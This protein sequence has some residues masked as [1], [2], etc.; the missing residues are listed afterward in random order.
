MSIAEILELRKAANARPAGTAVAVIGSGGKTT[1]VW[2]LASTFRHER[3]LVTT[4]VKMWLP[5][6]DQ[7]DAFPDPAVFTAAGPAAQAAPPGITFAGVR[8][9][10]EGKIGALPPEALA[11]RR[12]HFD[13]L[14]IEADGSR[15]RPYKGWADHEPVVPEWTDL[16]IAVLP[17]PQ[18][19]RIVSEACV[20]RLPEFLAISGA[21]PGEPLRPAHLAAA[22]A[23]PNGLLARARGR[24]VLFFSQ[25]ETGEA[26][27]AAEETAALLPPACRER[28]WKIVA[29]SACD[30]TA[31][32]I[33]ICRS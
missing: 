3:V 10:A 11:S 1:L 27:K 31:E 18:S 26:R 23:H 17:P 19:G 4:T 13:K 6:P 7:Y 2:L 33:G 21:V 29:G 14:F 16:T 15:R 22:I 9:S 20:H 25:V 32:A 5:E 30:N 24:I 28:L 8:L 12:T